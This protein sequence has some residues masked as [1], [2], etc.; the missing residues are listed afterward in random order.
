MNVNNPLSIHLAP[1]T[2]LGERANVGWKVVNGQSF[3]GYNDKPNLTAKP[4]WFKRLFSGTEARQQLAQRRLDKAE[5]YRDIIFAESVKANGADPKVIRRSIEGLVRQAQ[6]GVDLSK[7]QWTMRP[8]FASY[9]ANSSGYRDSLLSP[10]LV[11]VTKL[12][13]EEN[14]KQSLSQAATEALHKLHVGLAQS[15]ASNNQKPEAPTV[16]SKEADR[17]FQRA[18]DRQ[19]YE[20]QLVQLKAEVAAL[21][22]QPGKLDEYHA[23]QR[24]VL[25]VENELW[26]MDLQDQRAKPSPGTQSSSNS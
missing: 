18:A 15:V 20:K 24:K 2:A 6:H 16:K 5:L 26:I 4:T 13:Q 19:Q 8:D 17:L 1:R 22:G 11:H 10:A 25:G 14:H 23:A 12:I 3:L 7:I 21:A 9:Q